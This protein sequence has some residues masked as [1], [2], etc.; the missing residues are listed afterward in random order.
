MLHPAFLIAA[1]VHDDGW[2]DLPAAG[3]GAAF[4][5]ARAHFAP[6][7]AG[8]FVQR[9]AGGGRPGDWRALDVAFFARCL[10]LALGPVTPDLFAVRGVG[11]VGQSRGRLVRADPASHEA[12][13]R[14]IQG[15]FLVHRAAYDGQPT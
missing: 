11:A 1:A 4:P 7:G 3:H 8:G 5:V 12:R 2:I 13:L 15:A 6:D 10:A 14:V 9:V